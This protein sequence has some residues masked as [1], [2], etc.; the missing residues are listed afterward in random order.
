M[1]SI[2]WKM[3]IDHVVLWVEDPKEALAFYVDVLGLEAVRGQGYADGEVG[4]PSV[5]ISETAIVD[6]MARS[7]LPGVR[8]FTGGGDD[9]GGTPINHLCLAMNS[10]DYAALRARLEARGVGLTSGGDRAF[11]ARGEAARSEYF[12]DPDGNVLEMRHYDEA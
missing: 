3:D 5:R 10:M 12:C 7:S 2:G 11:G 9:S 6:L 4:F 8:K 1:R